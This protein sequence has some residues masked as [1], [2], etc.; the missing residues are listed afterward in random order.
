MLYSSDACAK[1]QRIPLVHELEGLCVNIQGFDPAIWMQNY[2]LEKVRDAESKEAPNP[3][4]MNLFEQPC[5]DSPD[6]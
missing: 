1:R 2:I 4:Q 3:K 5:K 6:H